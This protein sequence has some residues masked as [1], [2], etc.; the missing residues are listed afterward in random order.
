MDITVV[1]LFPEMLK[2]LT[3]S[4]VVGKA[5][6]RGDLVVNTVNPREFAHDRH[7]TV[8]DRP[9]GGGPGMV[10]MVEPLREAVNTAKAAGPER[11]VIYLSPQ[12]RKLD[13]QGLKEL[14]QR[15]G[16]ILV[17]GRYEGIDERFIETEVDEEWSIGD[18]VLSGGELAAM[19]MIDGVARLIPGVLGHD[20]SAEQDSFVNGLLDCPHYTRPENFEGSEVPKVLLSGDHQAIADWRLK[21]ALGR[22]WER[23]PDL[24]DDRDLDE[25]QQRLL[26]EY[27]QEQ[28]EST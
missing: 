1:T 21:Q 28:K 10:M 4:G 17:A 2:A 7:R 14:S 27:I 9:Y 8:D 20:E 26:N 24:L 16:M 3:E 13:Q 15:P 23:R 25:R 22:T 11:K 19:V 12:G 6:K 18:Y 5:V